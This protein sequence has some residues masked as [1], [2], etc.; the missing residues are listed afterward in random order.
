LQV[1]ARVAVLMTTPLIL[2]VVAV[3]VDLEQTVLLPLV[4]EQHTQ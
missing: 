4:L 3:Q 1:A 2:V